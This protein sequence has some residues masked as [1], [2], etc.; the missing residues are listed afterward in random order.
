[1]RISRWGFCALTSP[2]Y[3][4][5][6][7][8]D[9]R[10]CHPRG[11]LRGCLEASVAR[12]HLAV[13]DQALRESGAPFLAVDLGAVGVHQDDIAE[14]GGRPWMV[15]R[16]GVQQ[17]RPPAKASVARSVVVVSAWEPS[18]ACMNESPSTEWPIPTAWASSW[19]IAVSTL[20]PPPAGPK[21]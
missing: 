21:E 9:V 14:P 16:C 11:C 2:F 1:M 17:L 7:S 5:S 4:P 19:R 20:T 8:G 6:V 13:D 15:L 10:V 18:S 3:H 12:K